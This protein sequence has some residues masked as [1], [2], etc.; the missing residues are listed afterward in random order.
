MLG[1]NAKRLSRQPLFL[2]DLPLREAY[3]ASESR[4]GGLLRTAINELSIVLASMVALLEEAGVDGTV[5]GS[6]HLGSCSGGRL[7]CLRRYRSSGKLPGRCIALGQRAVLRASPDQHNGSC[8]CKTPHAG[9]LSASARSNRT[10]EQGLPVARS[11]LGRGH[12]LHTP[13]H[14][15]RAVTQVTA[16][17]T[18]CT[19]S[20]VAC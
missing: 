15:K 19:A 20:L 18:H 9:D 3:L 13:G 12:W 5:R 11:V 1:R 7:G 10:F 16:L 17:W 4:S 2:D 6:R 14:K 8:Y